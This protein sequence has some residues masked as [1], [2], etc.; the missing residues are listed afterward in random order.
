MDLTG[1]LDN[2]PVKRWEPPHKP[3]QAAAFNDH[4]IIPHWMYHAMSRRENTE[5]QFDGL[6]LQI[7]TSHWCMLET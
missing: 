4:V 7:L 6:M 5:R 1:E 2:G 3:P